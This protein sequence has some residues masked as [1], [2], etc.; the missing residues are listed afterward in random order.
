MA[1]GVQLTLD[2]RAEPLARSHGQAAPLTAVQ[3]TL[4]R[5]V[6][7]RETITSTEAGRIVHAHRDPPC[8]RCCRGCCGF[9]STDGSDALKRL[10]HRG[11]VRRIAAG[12]WTARETPTGA[13]EVAV[14]RADAGAPRG[15]KD[16]RIGDVVVAEG[17]HW[18]VEGLDLERREAISRL[19]GGSNA[20]RRF[21]ARRIAKVERGA[22]AVSPAP[23]PR[24][25]VEEREDDADAGR[26]LGKLLEGAGTADDPADRTGR[27]LER[28]LTR[29]TGAIRGTTTDATIARQLLDL[30]QPRCTP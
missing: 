7:E 28:T 9:T 30:K 16:A 27:L 4:L 18:R 10:A 13:S 5:A 15:P 14:T 8:E 20:L 2:G 3:L 29:E 12:L 6:V 19:L 11:L 22:G 26:D 21:R 17:S 23:P 25:L 24:G 1:S